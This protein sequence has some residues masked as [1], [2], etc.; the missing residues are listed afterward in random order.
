MEKGTIGR[1]S[2]ICPLL[3]QRDGP[4]TRQIS[5]SLD[6]KAPYWSI[7][8]IVDLGAAISPFP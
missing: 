5:S 3:S 8:R 6:I 2:A 4:L 1:R 7:H